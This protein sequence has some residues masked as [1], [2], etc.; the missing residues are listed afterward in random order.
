MPSATLR[1]GC[2]THTSRNVTAGRRRNWEQIPIKT[3]RMT[4]EPF[5]VRDRQGLGDSEY[6]DA[7][8]DVEQQQVLGAEVQ[9]CGDKPGHRAMLKQRRSWA[10]AAGGDEAEERAAPAPERVVGSRRHAPEKTCVRGGRTYEKPAP[11]WRQRA[12][13]H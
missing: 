9:P 7:Q 2:R 3:G 4:G 13:F 12:I 1:C 6:D 5:E 8:T 11:R 10:D